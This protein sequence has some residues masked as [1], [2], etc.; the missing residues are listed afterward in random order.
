MFRVTT[1]IALDLGVLA[2][3]SFDEFGKLALT[4][5]ENDIFVGARLAFNDVQSTQILAGATIDRDTG[6]SFINVEASRRF[7]DSWTL[8]VEARTFVG[9]PREDVFLHRIRKDGYIQLNWSWHF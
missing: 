1:G 6:A 3:Y 2:E 8:D 5:L 4:P 9:V 7:G